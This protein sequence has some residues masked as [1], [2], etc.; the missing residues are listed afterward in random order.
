MCLT[1]LFE[2]RFFFVFLLIREILAN[3][4]EKLWPL[5]LLK[6]VLYNTP[7]YQKKDYKWPLKK[8]KN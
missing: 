1:A 7:V 6:D 3:D 8:K 4:Y 5:D 2:G